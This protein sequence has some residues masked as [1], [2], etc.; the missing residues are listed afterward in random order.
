MTE[1]EIKE[2]ISDIRR[3]AEIF[4]NSGFATAG[5]ATVFDK[6]ADI[7]EE[8]LEYK[9]VG[10]VE[11][12][13]ALKEKRKTGVVCPVCGKLGTNRCEECGQDLTI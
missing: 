3:K 1:N 9:A 8:L 2:Y 5:V 12:F 4:R 13:K 11:E 6:S 7:I 10:T